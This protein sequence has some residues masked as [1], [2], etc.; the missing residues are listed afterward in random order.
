MH[1]KVIKVGGIIRAAREARG[2]TQAAL[3][4][5]TG[6]A[7]RTIIDI[8]KEKRYPTVE[9]LYK[10][11]NALDLPADYIFRPE[12]ACYTPEQEQVMVAVQS[13]GEQ[14]QTM[15]IEIGW[16][17]VQVSKGEKGAKKT[18]GD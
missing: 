9:N 15:Y 18:D 1:D 8:E 5:S 17:L 10:F 11:I 4:K 14:V 6:M 3:S 2:I 16:A 7:V 12:K 13:C